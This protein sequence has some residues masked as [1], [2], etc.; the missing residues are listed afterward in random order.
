MAGQGVLPAWVIGQSP[1]LREPGRP[2]PQPAVRC[3]VAGIDLPWFTRASCAWQMTAYNRHRRTDSHQLRPV[4]G[5][6][7]GAEAIKVAARAHQTLIWERTRQVQ[8]LRH[9]LR[10]YFPA[11]L[12]AFEDLAR[13]MRWN[14]WPRPPARTGPPG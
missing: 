14:C 10:E 4:A 11:V 12:E 7:A 8:R 1:G 13:L 6:S 2:I 9:L 3:C 5:D